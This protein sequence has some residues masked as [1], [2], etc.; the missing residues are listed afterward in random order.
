MTELFAVELGVII[1]IFLFSGHL[2]FHIFGFTHEVGDIEETALSLILD[3]YI[4][5]VPL[6]E[7]THILNF[8]AVYILVDVVHVVKILKLLL[9]L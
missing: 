3:L 9:L 6:T 5:V 2:L 8:V 4:V 1:F 7:L